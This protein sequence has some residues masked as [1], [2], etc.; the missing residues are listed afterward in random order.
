MRWEGRPGNP[1]QGRSPFFLSEEAKRSQ[2]RKGLQG[3]NGSLAGTM[4]LLKESQGRSL[5]WLGSQRRRGN[6]GHRSKRPWRVARK[7]SG[8]PEPEAQK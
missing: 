6:Q 7:D 3:K 4:T 1:T 8:E 2:S 5:S